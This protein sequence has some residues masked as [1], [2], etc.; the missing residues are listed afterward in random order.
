MESNVPLGPHDRFKATL[1]DFIGLMGEVIGDAAR[2]GHPTIDESMVNLALEITKLAEGEYLVEGFI[3]RSYSHWSKVRDRDQ[4]FFNSNADVIFSEASADIRNKIN[5]LFVTGKVTTEDTKSIWAYFE[6][7][8][9]ICIN[10]IKEKRTINQSYRPNIDL[11][12][13]AR[14]WS[15]I[16]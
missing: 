2:A 12:A 1:I 10:Y 5:D 15:I 8:I 3:D 9:R 11:Q 6:A 7:M 13:S 14:D 16:L 4:A